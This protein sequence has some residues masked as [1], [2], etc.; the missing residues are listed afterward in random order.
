MPLTF[1]S[2]RSLKNRQLMNTHFAGLGPCTSG[3]PFHIVNATLNLVAGK[4]L[5]WQERKADS[6]TFS[7]LHSG[8][9]RLGYRP[10]RVY[11][12]PGGVS[13]GTAVAISGAAASPNMGYHSSPALSFLL[14]LFNV[15][16]GWWLGNP[17]HAGEDTYSLRNPKVSLRPLLGELTGSTDEEHPYVYLSDGGHFENLGLY[18]MVLRRCHMIVLVDAA[19]DLSFGFDDLG[20]AVRKIRID[21]GVSVTFETMN[22]FP[23]SP[24]RPANAKYCALGTIHYEDVDGAGAQPGTLLYIK[25]AVY[26]DKESRDIYNYARQNP[27]FPHESTADQFFSESQFES[28]RALGE[29]TIK[30]ICTFGNARAQTVPE[31]MKAAHDYTTDTKT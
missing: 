10:S 18:E 13:L 26:F 20:N 25:P 21:L 1:D 29:T 8:N 15:R 16:L 6:F 5:A 30:D 19:A 12:G 22:I 3:K 27:E 4:E 24:E 2:S 7:P 31:L 9:R 28:Y 17:G 14:T 23:R 11:G